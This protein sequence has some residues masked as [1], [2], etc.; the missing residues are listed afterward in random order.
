MI[1]RLIKF[2]GIC[3]F[4]LA[5]V[6]VDQE[7]R[8]VGAHH[9]MMLLEQIRPDVILGALFLTGVDFCFLAGYDILALRYLV[10]KIPF[11]KVFAVAGL[12]FAVS[13]TTGHAYL[14]GGSLRY[15]FYRSQ[16]RKIDILKLITM[17]SLTFF[18]GMTVAFIGAVCLMP[19]EGV[20]LP[21]FYHKLMMGIGGILGSLSLMYILT[22]V[23]PQRSLKIRQIV[24][25]APSFLMTSEQMILGLGDILSSFFVFYVILSSYM[26][27]P[28][29]PILVIFILAQV[30]GL[31]SQIPGGLGVFEGVFLYLFSQIIPQQGEAVTALIVFRVLYY[32]V[33]FGMATGL[34]A[35]RWGYQKLQM[36]KT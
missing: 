35:L 30:I 31:S 14:A 13:N 12:G 25:R 28:F 17:D 9:I 8:R 32:F 15:L 7:I 19:V 36:K 26:A 29:L 21:P 24:I 18:L 16:L 33:P 3:F 6:L 20:S 4:I 5:L 1:N 2:I 10:R 27:V 22:V 11:F 34:L 23:W